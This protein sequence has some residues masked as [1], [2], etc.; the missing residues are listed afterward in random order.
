MVFTGHNKSWAY[1]NG[2]PAEN[3]NKPS[4]ICDLRKISFVMLKNYNPA[5]GFFYDFVNK[6]KI[7]AC[8][9]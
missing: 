1:S 2:S 3:K 5:T 4:F 6:H 7:R 9:K 8:W